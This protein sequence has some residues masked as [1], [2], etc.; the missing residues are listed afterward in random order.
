MNIDID[1]ELDIYVDIDTDI[2]FN[3]YTRMR[4]KGCMTGSMNASLTRQVFTSQSIRCFSRGQQQ[5][6]QSSAQSQSQTQASAQPSSVEMKSDKSWAND[7]N[8]N[9]NTHSISSEVVGM[10]RQIQETS[11][12]PIHIDPSFKKK[13]KTNLT[14]DPFDFSQDKLDI[15]KRVKNAQ[16]KSSTL[17]LNTK[18]T[19]PFERSGID[20]R[21]LYT[22]PEI[23][24]RFITSAGQILPRSVTGCNA[25]NQKKLGI[26]I[27]RSRATGML[28]STHKHA[29]YLPLR[30]L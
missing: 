3:M 6:Q 22:M 24:S 1:I 13:F 21:D 18:E 2:D 26:A 27:K 29:R 16:L 23:L 8:T 25:A 11:I 7:I 20:P 30:N 17:I 10:A 28:S 19:D 9:T 14:Y 4:L 5:Y 15:E 12:P